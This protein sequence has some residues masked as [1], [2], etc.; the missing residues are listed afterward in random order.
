MTGDADLALFLSDATKY[1]MAGDSLRSDVTYETRLCHKNILI[2][3]YGKN[4]LV[5]N[6]IS[7]SPCP[8]S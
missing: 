6:Y 8:E 2:P 5:D 1:G 3:Y 4:P 7:K